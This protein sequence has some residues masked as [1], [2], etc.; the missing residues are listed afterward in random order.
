[1]A[2]NRV[3]EGLAVTGGTL[4]ALLSSGIDPNSVPWQ[5][6]ILIL[7]IL[8]AALLGLIANFSEQQGIDQTNIELP[9]TNI[10][11]QR[12]KAFLGNPEKPTPEEQ[13]TL[14]EAFRIFLKGLFMT[15]TELWRDVL[16][17]KH[18][19]RALRIRTDATDFD[20]KAKTARLKKAYDKIRRKELLCNWQA[21]ILFCGIVVYCSSLLLSPLLNHKEQLFHLFS[22]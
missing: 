17:Q 4:A 22:R 11:K 9:Q 12:I 2:E 16:P 5:T 15:E 20:K 6:L 3:K 14:V 1:M 19:L 18:L 7:F 21:G 10:M 8:V 13:Q